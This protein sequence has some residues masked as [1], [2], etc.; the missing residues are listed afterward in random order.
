MVQEQIARKI[1]KG[2]FVLPNDKHFVNTEVESYCSLSSFPSQ[3]MDNS[4]LN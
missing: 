3:Q 2:D 4:Q 1:A